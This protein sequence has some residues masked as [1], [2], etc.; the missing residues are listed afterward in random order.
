MSPKLWITVVGFNS[1]AAIFLIGVIIVYFRPRLFP[2]MTALF[3]GWLAGFINLGTSE[4]QFPVLLLLAFGFF[5]GFTFPAGVWKRALMLG[6]FVPLSQ[7]VLFAATHDF[8]TV[9]PDGAGSLFAFFPAFAGSY[10]GK[11]ISSIQHDRQ[12]DL[13]KL[14]TGERHG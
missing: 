10:L 9:I 12:I 7:L 3:L 13:N 5:L 2:F 14:E 6:M 11:F 8:H 4:P 1:L